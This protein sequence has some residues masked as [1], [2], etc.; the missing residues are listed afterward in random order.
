MGRSLLAIAI[1][2]V[3]IAALT[4]GTDFALRAAVP[5]LYEANGGTFSAPVLM[6]MLAYVGMYAVGGCYVC[7]A[8]APSH[9]RV[10][11][12]VLGVLGLGATVWASVQQWELRPAWYHVVSIA[13]VLVYAGLGGQLR[14]MQ[15]DQQQPKR[16]GGARHA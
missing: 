6:L 4:L 15:L 1:S 9:P 7:A 3:A 5:S 13:L 10:H 14:I 11:A 12:A 16:I 2:F 8:L